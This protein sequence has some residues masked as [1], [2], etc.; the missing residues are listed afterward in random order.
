MALTVEDLKKQLTQT[1]QEFEN[2]KA[3]MY[4]ADGV[5]QL[6]RLQIAQAETEQAPETPEP[7]AEA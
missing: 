7:P 2:A 3:W 6:L 5:I 1:E 4:R